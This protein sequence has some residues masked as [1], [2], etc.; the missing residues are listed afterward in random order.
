V[1]LDEKSGESTS[2]EEMLIE[3]IAQA[4]LETVRQMS[5]KEKA[6]L[7]LQL[8]GGE[9]NEE[10]ESLCG[11]GGECGEPSFRTL[12]GYPICECGRSTRCKNAL[13]C[14]DCRD[15]WIVSASDKNLLKAMGIKC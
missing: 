15:G 8:D 13:V 11:V 6:K 1:K 14:R 5:P 12:K 3:E 2:G 7:R 4:A 10:L 9:M